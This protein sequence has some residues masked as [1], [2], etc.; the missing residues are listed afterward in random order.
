MCLVS[1]SHSMT[2]TCKMQVMNG[3][4]PDRN[5]LRF[6][7]G[8]I[9]DHLLEPGKARLPSGAIAVRHSSLVRCTLA[10]TGTFAEVQRERANYATRTMGETL[11]LSKGVPP[12]D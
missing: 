1:T 9:G 4:I 12:K 7:L 8:D 11:S 6:G 2:P 5:Q 10:T 3:P